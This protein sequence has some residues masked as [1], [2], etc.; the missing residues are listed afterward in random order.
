MALIVLLIQFYGFLKFRNRLGV[1][2]LGEIGKSDREPRLS[3]D[4]RPV[5]IRDAH[6]FRRGEHFFGVILGLGQC[7]GFFGVGS[8]KA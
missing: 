2:V 7:R 3:L 5:C 8:G 1:R 4:R 6:R